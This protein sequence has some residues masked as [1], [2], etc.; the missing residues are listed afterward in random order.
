MAGCKHPLGDRLLA[1]VDDVIALARGR[2]WAR[3][4]IEC[5]AARLDV[6][7]IWRDLGEHLLGLTMDDGEMLLHDRLA[8][9]ERAFVFAHELAH[10]LRR[11]GRF[12][13]VGTASEE[14]FA[15]WFARE[16]VLP[17]RVARQPLSD[18]QL[19]ALHVSYETVAL[20]R[21]VLD[22]MPRLMRKGERVLCRECGTARY[23]PG[24]ECTPWRRRDKEYRNALPDVR[25]CLM[26]SKKEP[27]R[28]VD[29]QLRMGD[30]SVCMVEI[31]RY[32]HHS[33]HHGVTTLN[34]W[35]A[36]SEGWPAAQPC[37]SEQGWCVDA[38][39]SYESGGELTLFA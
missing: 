38:P 27:N 30:G 26:R 39:I 34:G 15:D 10:V 7:I 35:G 17:R 23:R 24:C 9:A 6:S 4:D 3:L 8:G 5:A 21:A 19:A 28:D 22:E 36:F 37:V 29:M 31:K 1:E 25:E 32:K 20:Q 14:W 16:L 13:S 33:A 11:R 18:A 2:M 12:R